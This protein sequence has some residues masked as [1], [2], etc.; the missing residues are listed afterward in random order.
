MFSFALSIGSR[1]KNWKTKPMC[2]RRSFVRSLSP[3][4][5]ISVPAIP[6]EPELG[7]S[8]PARMCMRVDLPEPDG[9]ITAVALRRRDVDRHPAEG[10]DGGIPFSVSARHVV[11]SDDRAVWRSHSSHP[12]PSTQLRAR[13]DTSSPTCALALSAECITVRLWRPA[14]RSGGRSSAGARQ[15]RRC[16][17]PSPTTTSSRRSRPRVPPLV[18]SFAHVARF[19][20][21]WILRTLAERRPDP[22]RP[23]PRLRRVPPRA[24]ERSQ[25]PD[26]EPHGRARIRR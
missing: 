7:L 20:E 21:L 16:S 5:V 12:A 9:P 24:L 8:R 2:S 10:V 15:R 26:A 17:P 4:V 23:R 14:T 18:W 3:S 1:L 25:A 22:G 11:C 13:N 6:T 19:E